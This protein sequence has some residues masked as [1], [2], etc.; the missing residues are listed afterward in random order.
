MVNMFT[1]ASI[2]LIGS[3]RTLELAL[4]QARE[5]GHKVGKL[6]MAGS[7]LKGNLQVIGEKLDFYGSMYG[8]VGN[9]TKLNGSILEKEITEC[10]CKGSPIEVCKQLEALSNGIC[11]AINPDYVLELDRRMSEGETSCHWAIRKK[12]EPV[13]E[14]TKEEA[15][16]DDLA[17]RLGQ[18]YI[19]GEITAEELEKKLAHLR[20]LGLVK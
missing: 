4:P 13:K 6:L 1:S 19:D 5:T 11:E 8:R 7:D 15:P 14:K 18:K 2:Q 10:P 16:S 17:K 12:G 3:E 9:P 20:K